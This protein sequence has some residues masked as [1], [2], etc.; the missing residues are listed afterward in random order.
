MGSIRGQ[1]LGSSQGRRQPW[2][3]ETGPPARQRQ[4]PWQ[5]QRVAKAGTRP[6]SHCLVQRTVP[7][8][9]ISTPPPPQALLHSRADKSQERRVERS[10]PRPCGPRIWAVKQ[11]SPK[12]PLQKP[13]SSLGPEVEGAR[14]SKW[15]GVPSS[16]SS[17]RSWRAGWERCAAPR[18]ASRPACRLPPAPCPSWATSPGCGWRAT[19]R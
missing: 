12:L 17:S 15:A 11:C 19:R 10:L 6:V 8:S 2:K 13:R 14:E 5:L 1:T 18:C 4:S 9:V 3:R 7:E 16:A